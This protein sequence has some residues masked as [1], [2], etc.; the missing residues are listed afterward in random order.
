M[1]SSGLPGSKLGAFVGYNYYRNDVNV[2]GCT[3]IAGNP[4]ICLLLAP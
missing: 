2:Y 4:F 3:Q 1:T